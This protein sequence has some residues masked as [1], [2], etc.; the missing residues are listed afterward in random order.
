[1]LL[2]CLF[3]CHIGNLAL[4]KKVDPFVSIVLHYSEKPEICSR[5][6][7]EEEILLQRPCISRRF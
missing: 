5:L 2:N 7:L 4:R 6:T 1:M 3:L